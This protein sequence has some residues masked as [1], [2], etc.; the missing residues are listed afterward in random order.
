MGAKA[1]TSHDQ[2]LRERLSSPRTLRLIVFTV[3]MHNRQ[4]G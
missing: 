4:W 3:N 1:N 2:Y